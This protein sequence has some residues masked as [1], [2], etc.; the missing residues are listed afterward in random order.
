MAAL[1]RRLTLGFWA[2]TA[3]SL[4][5]ALRHKAMIFP[6][7]HQNSW[8]WFLGIPTSRS[9]TAS[10]SGCSHGWM[11]LVS[12]LQSSW[13][14]WQ[15][16]G[17]AHPAGS[18]AEW[19]FSN[20]TAGERVLFWLELRPIIC[21]WAES[22]QVACVVTG[23]EMSSSSEGLQ[24]KCEWAVAW[25]RSRLRHWRAML[26]SQLWPETCLSFRL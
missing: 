14:V 19:V 7:V 6:S 12:F 5:D 20:G 11:L 25:C 26:S 13:W 4:S 3:S 15:S 16:S 8:I 22:G 10:C 21:Y 2:R 23:S 18:A 1:E 17:G 24:P 9:E